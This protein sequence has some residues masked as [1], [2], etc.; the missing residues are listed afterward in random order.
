MFLLPLTSPSFSSEL[1]TLGDTAS[2]RQRMKNGE[3]NCK[4][5]ESKA[6]ERGNEL[7]SQRIKG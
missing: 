4:V 3:M 6:D 7:R 5:K 1:S 2:E